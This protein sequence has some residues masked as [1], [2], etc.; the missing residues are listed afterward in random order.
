MIRSM[1]RAEALIVD[2]ILMIFRHGEVDLL[3]CW[4]KPRGICWRIVYGKWI[5][6]EEY[7]E[8]NGNRDKLRNETRELEEL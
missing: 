3:S 7:T 2:D 8:R 5:L 6:E 1:A 4:R